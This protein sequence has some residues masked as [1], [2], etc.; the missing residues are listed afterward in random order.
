MRARVTTKTTLRR[1]SGSR[2]R[3]N[4]CQLVA[5]S[6]AAA[7]STS[8]GM[9][10]SPARKNSMKVPDVVHTVSVMIATIATDG[11]ASQFQRLRLRT[12][13]SSQPGGL[14]GFTSPVPVSR[15]WISPRESVNHLGPWMP[16]K[17]RTALTA[18]L[19]WNRNRNVTPIATEL[20]I[21]GK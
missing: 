20:V 2:T 15:I 17:A 19:P 3:Q 7:S 13:V 5:P 10:C 9:F 4:R 18:P 16:K 12:C 11:P 1:M 8:T 14:R 6:T 21:D